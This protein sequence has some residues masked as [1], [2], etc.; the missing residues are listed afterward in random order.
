MHLFQLT[1]SCTDPC[2]GAIFAE[3]RRD[4][5]QNGISILLEAIELVSILSNNRLIFLEIFGVAF[6]EMRGTLLSIT[7]V[8]L[9]G[10]VLVSGRIE[11]M[12]MPP[13][14]Q[15]CLKLIQTKTSVTDTVGEDI[16][17]TCLNS[18]LSQPKKNDIEECNLS[19]KEW[20]KFE[21]L[22]N[23]SMIMV[24]GVPKPRSGIRTRQEY[25]KLTDKARNAFHKAV[26]ELNKSGEFK[27]FACVHQGDVLKSGHN[28]TNFLGW[29]RVYLAMYEEALRRIDPTVALP[30]WDYTLDLELEDPTKS[31]VWSPCF[32][33]N[34]R[35]KV[36]T[37]PFANWA[38]HLG[39]LE[40]NI[41]FS[42]SL[43]HKSNV[44][45]ILSKCRTKDVTYPGCDRRFVIEINHN[46][47]HPWVGGA[48]SGFKSAA[49]DPVFFLHHAMVDYIWQLFRDRQRDVCYVDPSTDY[50]NMPG[51]K[52]HAANRTMDRFPMFKNI[53]G[54][55]S[56]WED[57]WYKYEPSPTC[58]YE[59]DCGSA[60]LVCQGG[61][62]IP[63]TAEECH[64]N[65]TRAYTKAKAITGSGNI[66]LEKKPYDPG[67]ALITPIQN[68]FFINGKADMKLWAFVP[69]QVIYMKPTAE[70]FPVYRVYN[71]KLDLNQ[72]FYNYPELNKFI[73]HG[74]LKE[75][76]NCKRNPSGA[77]QIILESNGINYLG[78]YIEYTI[79]DSRLLVGTSMVYIG[80]KNP[81]FENT[82]A[83]I[84]AHDRCGRMCQP[85]CLDRGSNP[86]KYRPCSGAIRISPASPKMYG[87]TLGDA[88]MDVWHLWGR[89][90]GNFANKFELVMVCNNDGEWP[91][92]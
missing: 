22:I 90:P 72:D 52:Y 10:S 3:S 11:E 44:S 76:S 68:N 78:R 41:G 51:E 69:I 59:Q 56:Y 37:G 84:S 62:C 83:I 63:K 40:R 88:I 7:L 60:W 48:M 9:I 8:A 5:D 49:F 42:G 18:F 27:L 32:M 54:Y 71:D 34:G 67:T 24:A 43:T 75:Y 14:L 31:V 26:I 74:H 92:K 1:N 82:E 35:G 20:K 87:N 6:L 25:R 47:V 55:A 57:H 58:T 19:E 39:N 80:V 38:T 17:F 53:D 85:Q 23:Q 70:S 2:L 65:V 45:D 29:H 81:E 91:W 15:S 79:T 4:T 50:P 89:D 77:N 66:F 86:A 16:F 13:E 28:G 12:P 64:I 73:I 46:P 36:N 61:V 30:Y 33:G 21:R